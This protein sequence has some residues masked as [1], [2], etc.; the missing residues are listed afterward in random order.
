MKVLL[1]YPSTSPVSIDQPGLSCLR[2]YC[3]ELLAATLKP[4][5]EVVL[6]DL[7][8][9]NDLTSAL[10]RHR[11]DVVGITGYTKH[12]SQMLSC[13]RRTK[14]Y[15]PEIRTIVGGIHATLLPE[16]FYVDCVDAILTGEDRFRFRKLV[17][18]W[19]N[20]GDV[21]TIGGLR[22][23]CKGTWHRGTGTV[24]PVDLDAYPFADH[25]ICAPYDNC[26][27][28]ARNNY[29]FVRTSL[30]CPYRCT[31]CS[32]WRAVDGRYYKRSPASVIEEI[33]SSP[34][35]GEYFLVD[36]E[37][38]IDF[39]RMHELAQLIQKAGIN[40]FFH[41]ECRSDTI[42]R[43]PDLIEQWRGV[44]LSVLTVGLESLTDEQLNG[45]NKRTSVST[46]R[47][48]IQHLNRLGIVTHGC[49]IT[50]QNWTE[51]DFKT[52]YKRVIDLFDECP[53]FL[54]T[55]SVLTPF[56]G[57]VLYDEVKRDLITTDYDFFDG[58]HSVLPTHLPLDAYYSEYFQLYRNTW[59]HI[60]KHSLWTENIQFLERDDFWAN[61]NRRMEHHEV[62]G[63]FS[64]PIS[65]GC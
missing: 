40:Q 48:A 26:Y 58:Y 52:T 12:Y 15:D 17:D 9:E 49:F 3:F 20:D 47:Q 46:N 44:G 63:H 13:L 32:C 37:S 30:G 24:P 4:R 36:D 27:R 11:P 25:S 65:T 59:D 45:F 64:L 54:P 51:D 35:E 31:F 2:P 33:K 41:T 50:G 8:I 42:C 38:F 1:T 34:H 10:D 16:D 53:L 29:R 19:E 5:H 28:T 57:T 7:R 43:H 60:R 6:A 23:R 22:F 62:A 14:D 56:P 21:G 55:F 39:H 18:L 61:L